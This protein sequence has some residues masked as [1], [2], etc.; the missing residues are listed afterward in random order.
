MHQPHP[1]QR[2]YRVGFLLLEDFTAIAL[3]SAIGPLRLANYIS[4]QT[5]YEWK[6]VN[7]TG[8]HVV[9]SDG[10]RMMPDSSIAETGDFDLVIVVAGIDVERHF[11]DDEMRWLKS[12]SKR[13]TAL[14]GVCTGAYVLARTGLL[15]D[16]SCS[17]H[18][19][20]L[21]ALREEF[22]DVR[23]NT[24]LYTLDRDRLTC[25]GGTVPMHM[26][27]HLVG[28]HQGNV[29]A[30]SVSDM[31]V[32]DR[33]REGHE[34]QLK[35]DHQL[36]A[37]KPK[38]AEAVQLMEANIEEPIELQE[39]AFYVGVSRRHLERMFLNHLNCTPS[40]F[41]LKLRLEHARQLLKQTSRSIVDIASMC[42]FAS[43]THFSRC[44]HKYMGKP[45]KAERMNSKVTRLDP[46]ALRPADLS[47]IVVDAEVHD[48]WLEQALYE[49]M[50][51][52]PDLNSG[53]S[54]W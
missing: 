38:L 54:S 17:A 50:L 9:T 12:L 42:G 41:Y 21:A 3:S 51:V 34:P 53:G 20:C 49:P 43:A 13:R 24:Q 4:K 33:L 1:E 35:N 28:M 11:G 23:S 7:A 37:N 31:L 27:L 19:E 8:E 10:T 15:N 48:G 47:L 2:P 40:R 14:G 22:P 29:L 30:N 46:D 44:Y 32:C 6:L 26:M 16:Y 52:E 18:W 45:P 25:T 39:I 5:L 36:F